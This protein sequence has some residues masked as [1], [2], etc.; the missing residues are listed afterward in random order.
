MVGLQGSAKPLDQ[1]DSPLG[2]IAAILNAGYLQVPILIGAFCSAFSV[3]LACV[4]TAGPHP[5]P[6]RWRATA[7]LPAALAKI[8]PKHRYTARRRHHCH[9]RRGGDR[10]PGHVGRRA[11]LW[12]TYS[13]TAAP[14][15]RSGFIIIYL[16]ISIAA[17]LYV[18]RIG[19]MKFK[20]F[21]DFR[22]SP[23]FVLCRRSGWCLLESGGA[24]EVVP[25]LLHRI[26]TARLAMVRME[27]ISTAA[28]VADLLRERISAGEIEPGSRIVELDVARE[29]AVS[30]S[31]IREALLK[32]SEEGLV[33][34]LPYRGAI[35]VALR[36][37]QI[38][39][40]LEFRLA[41]ERFAL[42]RLLESRDAAALAMLREH[43]VANLR[44]DPCE[45]FQAG[46]RRGSRNA[47]LRSLRLRATSYS[48]RPTMGCSPASALYISHH[49][50]VL[51]A[52]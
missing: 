14:S 34:I 10:G 48:R 47:P 25:D 27:R 28:R 30:R 15:A 51:R 22:R 12:S 36:R 52:S 44:G 16:L 11:P 26:L 23:S 6:T 45:G 37:E 20:D 17:G 7:V 5:R 46:G 42:E 24:A 1:L 18:K 39:E 3:C 38:K 8:E 4:T 41:L 43:V 49:E 29:L 32:L 31:P 2:V 13:I 33:Q 21:C 50:R 40:L 35:V 9:R 19:A